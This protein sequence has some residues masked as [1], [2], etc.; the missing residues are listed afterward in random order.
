ML[1]MAEI[2]VGLL[3]VV[4][5]VM[6][7][8]GSHLLRRRRNRFSIVTAHAGFCLDGL[9]IFWIGV[10]RSLNLSFDVYAREKVS[11]P[12]YHGIFA[13]SHHWSA[14]HFGKL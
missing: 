6:R 12:M 10:S 11:S 5:R 2:A 1:M 13:A 14:P 4:R 7:I 8:G 9:R 3:S